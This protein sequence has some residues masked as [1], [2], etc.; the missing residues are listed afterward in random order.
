[1]IWAQL[2]P[3]NDGRFLRNF[4]SIC[5]L[6]SQMRKKFI[7]IVLQHELTLGRQTRHVSLTLTKVNT[8]GL[9]YHWQ[10]SDAS[11]K[12]ILLAGH[13]GVLAP[14]ITWIFHPF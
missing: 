7:P 4:R 10:G 6:L 14:N 9:V 2:T 1:M 11:L 3:T 5:E 12:P 13:Q 8:Y